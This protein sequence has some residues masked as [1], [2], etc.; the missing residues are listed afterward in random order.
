MK[1]LVLNHGTG[2]YS[3][4]SLES[5]SANIHGTR[6]FLVKIQRPLSPGGQ[7]MLIYDRQKSI[8]AF[9]L[10]VDNPDAYSL[11][12]DEMKTGYMGIKIYRWAKRIG[13]RQLSIC[14]D[15]APATDPDW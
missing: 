8:Q 5:I 3:G 2:H 10:Q 7:E 12:M 9:M 15:K 11:A 1:L 14:F 6:P 4:S 13:E